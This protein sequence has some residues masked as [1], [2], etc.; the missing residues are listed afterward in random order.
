M[1]RV[2]NWEL[3]QRRARLMQVRLR[4]LKEDYENS[5]YDPYGWPG[6]MIAG[7][8]QAL[9]EVHIAYEKWHAWERHTS[10]FSKV[11]PQ[12]SG[13]ATAYEEAQERLQFVY[14]TITLVLAFQQRYAECPKLSNLS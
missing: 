4:P 1:S 9:I 13:I 14:E 2:A 5:P 11:M 3:V 8:D 6:D 7:A 12:A 10:R